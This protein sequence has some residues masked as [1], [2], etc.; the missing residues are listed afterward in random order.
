MTARSHDRL[1]PPLWLFTLLFLAGMIWLIVVLKEMVV[2]LVVGYALAYVMHPLLTRMEGHRIPRGI[3]I[4]LIVLALVLFVTILFLTAIPTIFEQYEALSRN[5]PQYITT[6]KEKLHLMLGKAEVMFPGFDSNAISIEQIPGLNTDAVQQLGQAAFKTLVRGYSFTLALV[7][8]FLLPF[9]VFYLAVDFRL[10]HQWALNLFPV[11]RQ[12][13]VR[14]IAREIDRYVAAFVR[15]QLTVCSILFVL[16]A[17]GLRIVG[18]DLW[19][20]L[21]VIAG[22]GNMIPY[23][24]FLI[25]I[26]LSSIMSLATFGDFYHLVQVWIVF[27]VVQAMEGTLITPRVMG[28]NVGLSPL[29][30]ILA[31]YTGGALFGLLGIFLAV[32][33]AAALKVL[34]KH[35][36]EQVVRLAL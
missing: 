12:D 7:N 20:L 8:V 18:V 19:L 29:M 13:S 31:I 1:M 6:A 32:P 30:V 14:R 33:A 36:H 26:I 16:Y 4:V 24:G 15:G 23:L 9:I 11:I 22:F 27:T 2:L 21:A 34:A 5:L 17:I 10:I 25:G 28:A 35:L 3:G